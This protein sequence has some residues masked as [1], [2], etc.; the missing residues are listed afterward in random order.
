MTEIEHDPGDLEQY[1]GEEIPDPWSD[2]EQA[3]WPN[4]EEVDDE[5]GMGDDTER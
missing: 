5:H 4:E 2:P 1:A 3:D